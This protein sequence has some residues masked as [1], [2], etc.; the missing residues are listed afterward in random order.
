[1]AGRAAPRLLALAALLAAAPAGARAPSDAPLGVATP[2][3]FRLLFLDLPLADA[4]GTARPTPELRWFLANSWSVPTAVMRGPDVVRLRLDAQVDTLQLAVT[5]PWDR[6]AGGALARRLTTTVE[7]RVQEVWGG[8]TDG[9]IEAWHGLVGSVN[10]GRQRWPRDAVAVRLA[11]DGGPRLVDLT[12][13]RL[14]L[15]DLALRTALRLAGGGAGARAALA[16]RLDLKLP[17]GALSR[18]GGSGGA[19]AGLGL[20]GTRAFTPWLTGHALASLRVVSRLPRR[21][22]LQP[23]RLQGGLDLSA[24]VRAGPVALVVEDRI[25]TPLMESGWRLPASEDGPASTGYYALFRPHNQLTGGVRW[26]GVTAYLSEDFTPGGGRIRG[27]RGAPWFV[28]ANAPDV[29]L[30]LAWTHER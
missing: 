9:G 1:M 28:N 26:R 19:D 25:S 30:G 5:V 7:A 24:V 15:G 20:A 8:W 27:D 12:A 6:L 11:Q 17:T 2:G 10:F 23:R 21:M 29:V 22:A 4:R 3:P 18:L 16:L 14:G 13:P